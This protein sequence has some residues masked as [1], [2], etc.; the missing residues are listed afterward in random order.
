MQPSRG[1]MFVCQACE[2][3]SQMLYKKKAPVSIAD[4]VNK[5]LFV[6][7]SWKFRDAKLDTSSKTPK[8]QKLEGI[9]G[10][11]SLKPKIPA[12]FDSSYCQTVKTV[13]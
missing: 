4:G 7:K 1:K 3:S 10:T 9:S 11:R 12:S 6:L 8:L 13:Q 2:A 5:I